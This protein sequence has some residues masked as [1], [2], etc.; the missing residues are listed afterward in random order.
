M[1]SSRISILVVA[2]ATVSPTTAQFSGELPS[3][4]EYSW[5]LINWQVGLS[6][7]NP[8]LPSTSFYVFGVQGPEFAGI[9]AFSAHCKGYGQTGIPYTSNYTDC[10]SETGSSVAARITEAPA[11]VSRAHLA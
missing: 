1:Y 3:P 6:H 4:E 9:P 5:D 2:A 10:A 8:T 11:G 7:G